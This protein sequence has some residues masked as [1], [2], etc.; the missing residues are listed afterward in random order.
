[1]NAHR[2]T[3]G[4][5]YTFQ[6]FISLIG[7]IGTH[8]TEDIQEQWFYRAGVQFRLFSD[9][10]LRAGIYEDYKWHEKGNGAGIAW[11]QPKLTFD[12]SINNSEV[13]RSLISNPMENVTIKNKD[14]TFA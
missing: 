11:V 10:Y 13:K 14:L 8:Y 1:K 6:K 4:L 12:V 3:M 9:F 7:D 2:V 5:Q